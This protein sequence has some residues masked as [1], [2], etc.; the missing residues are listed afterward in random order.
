MKKLGVN[1]KAMSKKRQK[2]LNKISMSVLFVKSCSK[3]LPTA[4]TQSPK[5]KELQSTICMISGQPKRITCKKR[6]TSWSFK[7]TS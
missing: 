5:E 3:S 4:K 7:N 6:V 1:F 2:N